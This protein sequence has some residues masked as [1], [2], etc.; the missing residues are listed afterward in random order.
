MTST[1]T[2]KKDAFATF[3][4]FGTA[5]YFMTYGLIEEPGINS[6]RC[7]VNLDGRVTVLNLQVEHASDRAKYIAYSQAGLDPTVQHRIVVS[8]PEGAPLNVDAFM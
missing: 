7:W 8:N 5:I 1:Y 4:F 2:S 3:Q 6:M